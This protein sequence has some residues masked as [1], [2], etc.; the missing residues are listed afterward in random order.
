MGR[1]VLAVLEQLT[2]LDFK[3]VY[4][5]KEAFDV[6]NV[7]DIIVFEKRCINLEDVY[8]L[9]FS[10]VINCLDSHEDS[11]SR[12]RLGSFDA[13]NMLVEVAPSS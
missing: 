9:D 2:A 4:L 8:F 6:S 10:D 3:V 13:Q 12:L 1:K 7:S 5:L 11:Q